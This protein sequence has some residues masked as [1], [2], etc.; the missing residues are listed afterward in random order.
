MLAYVF[1]TETPHFGVTV[2]DGTVTLSDL[3]QGDYEIRV[4]H[5]QLKGEVGSTAQRVSVGGADVSLSISIQQ[6]RVWRA[7]RAP[8]M[9]R[10]SYR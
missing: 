3:P 6:K 5:P 9:G 4:W 7:R 10:G 1:V 2:V 8:S